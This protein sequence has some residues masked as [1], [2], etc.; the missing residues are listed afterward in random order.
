MDYT[1]TVGKLIALRSGTYRIAAAQPH[2]SNWVLIVTK[3]EGSRKWMVDINQDGLQVTQ[4]ANLKT[5]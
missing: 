5:I 4:L 3:P 1:P 2:K